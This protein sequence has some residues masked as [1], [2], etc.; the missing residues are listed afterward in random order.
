M[1]RPLAAFKC[2]L[3]APQPRGFAQKTQSKVERGD[4]TLGARTPSS[5]NACAARASP[6]KTEAPDYCSRCALNAGEG[7]RAPSISPHYHSA[8]FWA[9]PAV[10]DPLCHKRCDRGDSCK[11]WLDRNPRI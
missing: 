11:T 10:A 1:M 7:A 3:Q 4:L 2:Q 8:S 6:K 5:A 9:K